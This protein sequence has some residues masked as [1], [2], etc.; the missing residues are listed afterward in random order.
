MITLKR[1]LFCHTFFMWV[2]LNPFFRLFVH[3]PI[4]TF[5]VGLFVWNVVS[6]GLLWPWAVYVTEDD[7]E[8]LVPLLKDMQHYICLHHI[9]TY[10][11]ETRYICPSLHPPP[12]ISSSLLPVSFSSFFFFYIQRKCRC[13]SPFYIELFT[14]AW[15]WMGIHTDICWLN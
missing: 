5:I 9:L 12:L 10:K 6:S 13:C 14:Y 7:P 4:D 1:N 3:L 8:L 15:A 11:T 2:T